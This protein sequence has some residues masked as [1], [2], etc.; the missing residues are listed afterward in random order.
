[1]KCIE[2]KKRKTGDNYYTYHL[3]DAD[4][5]KTIQLF[6]K[7]GL[8]QSKFDKTGRTY[9]GGD[10]STYLSI[11]GSSDADVES[12]E[13]SEGKMVI[14][15][16]SHKGN[17]KQYWVIGA[18]TGVS[19]VSAIDHGFVRFGPASVYTYS[20]ELVDRF[21]RMVG[22]SKFTEILTDK[23]NDP[24]GDSEG[25]ETVSEDDK[26]KMIDAPDAATLE[27]MSVADL[28]KLVAKKGKDLGLATTAI[29]QRPKAELINFILTGEVPKVAGT[30]DQGEAALKMM[31]L[32]TAMMPKASMD[33]ERVREIVKEVAGL[34]PQRIVL[35]KADKTEID[36]GI[37]HKMFG[38]ICKLIELRMHLM[39]VGP[40]G[41]GKTTACENAAKHCGLAF[42]CIS[43]GQQTTKTDLQ[44]FIDANGVCRSPLLRQAYE[45]GG[46]FL[47]DEVDAGSANTLTVLNALLANSVC[48][49]PDG[50]VKRHPDFVCIAAGNTFGRGADRLYV[51]RNQLD[52]A[53]LDRFKVLDFDYD[54]KLEKAISPNDDWTAH[55][56]K[57]RKAIFDCKERVVCSPRA[58]MDSGKILNVGAFTWKETEEM[59]IWKGMAPDIKSKILAHC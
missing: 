15:E 23:I 49:F 1:M 26:R 28:R 17:G 3:E 19:V 25:V 11:T 55:V 52:A 18:I 56:Q 31:E 29:Q 38:A 37:Q 24:L 36:A 54:E 14:C 27:A 6:Q 2:H 43:V 21:G 20:G 44:G 45:F 10:K 39:L 35:V 7:H 59:C 58:S 12:K 50:M 57:I 22:E 4:G 16:Y 34:T 46:V 8:K 32:L 33:E 40:A 48:A 53:S 13:N 51:G 41:S 47:L 5:V 30:I 42:Y 9:Y